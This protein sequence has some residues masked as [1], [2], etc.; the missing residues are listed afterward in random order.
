MQH[1]VSGLVG[2][3][4]IELVAA[5]FKA[6]RRC[7]LPEARLPPAVNIAG[8]QRAGRH[9]LILSS[10]SREKSAGHDLY[11]LRKGGRRPDAGE[12]QS[13]NPRARSGAACIGARAG[14]VPL[15]KNTITRDTTGQPALGTSDTGSSSDASGV[16]LM[17]S[18]Y[19]LLTRPKPAAPARRTK[20]HPV[21]ASK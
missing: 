10:G 14:P 3:P 5:A 12:H 18:T 2:L 4:G 21:R 20:S 9:H 8:R 7:R 11:E 15:R 1:S 13:A 17:H 6:S 19:V 16:H